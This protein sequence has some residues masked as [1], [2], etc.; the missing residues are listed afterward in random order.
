[1]LKA[2]LLLISACILSLT[3]VGC[4]KAEASSEDIKENPLLAESWSAE[5]GQLERQV[6]LKDSVYD[7]LPEG[8][9]E[10]DYWPDGAGPQLLPNVDMDAPIIISRM[11][12]Y[13]NKCP[14]VKSTE[15]LE[16]VSNQGGTG[17][18]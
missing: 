4:S 5:T 3:L 9:E 7:P 14:Q 16:S 6:I 8:V 18:N 2:K 10:V 1:M 17:R 12:Y 13:E 11:P 15:A